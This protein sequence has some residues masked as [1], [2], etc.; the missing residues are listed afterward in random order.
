MEIAQDTMH[1]GACMELADFA[2]HKWRIMTCVRVLVP[3][4]GPQRCPSGF[5]QS[6]SRSSIVP[7]TDG[8]NLWL[9]L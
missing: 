5:Q 8:S 9:L 1:P 2:S 6:P 7:G 4:T 3:S